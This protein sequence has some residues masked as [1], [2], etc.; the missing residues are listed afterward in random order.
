MSKQIVDA[1]YQNGA[2]H[3]VGSQPLSIEEG[4]RVQVVID[5]AASNGSGKNILDLAT[6]VYAGL[7]EEEITEVERIATDRSRFFSEGK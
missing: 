6:R 3:L 2:F 5:D 4:K 1:V 7:S